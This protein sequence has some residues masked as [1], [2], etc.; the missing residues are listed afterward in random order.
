MRVKYV[1]IPW[2]DET[3]YER[4]LEVMTDRHALFPHYRDWLAVAEQLIDRLQAQG[5]IPV[6]AQIKPDAFLA[7]CRALNIHPDSQAR[8]DYANDCALRAHHQSTPN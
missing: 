2:Y 8:N 1:G 5:F 6:K 4:V 7:W 3:D